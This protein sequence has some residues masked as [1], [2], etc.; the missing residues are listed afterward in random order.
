MKINPLGLSQAITQARIASFHGKKVSIALPTNNTDFQI[1]NFRDGEIDSVITRDDRKL[2][3][4]M[5]VRISSKYTGEGIAIIIGFNV[6]GKLLPVTVS[7]GG[8]EGE[9]VVCVRLEEITTFPRT[10]PAK[11]AI[12][13]IKS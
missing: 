4:G 3:R 11:P 6:G 2:K 10:N 12:I 13:T 1:I 9:F 5:I 8:V 7:M